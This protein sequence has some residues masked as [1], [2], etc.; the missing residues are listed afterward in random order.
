MIS[1][2]YL[3]F[4]WDMFYKL[5]YFCLEEELFF[6]FRG[7]FPGNVLV[8]IKLE[9][10]Y[11]LWWFRS[12]TK[13]QSRRFIRKYFIFMMYRTGVN[14]LS[15]VCQL[16]AFI[17]ILIFGF[18]EH[19]SRYN[20]S[21]KRMYSVSLNLCLDAITYWLLDCKKTIKH[22]TVFMWS[23]FWLDVIVIDYKLL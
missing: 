11:T 14:F 4:S 7:I 6:F 5:E 12:K 2:K 19:V 9:V 13:L 8:V 17:E 18:D 23:S 21:S 1:I 20:L 10:L 22:Y 16:N 3:M 15:K